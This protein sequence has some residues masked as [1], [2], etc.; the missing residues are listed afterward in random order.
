MNHYS[1]FLL[2]QEMSPVYDEKAKK[3]YD[4]DILQTAK[5]KP[6]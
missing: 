5:K 4:M 6:G 1:H 2:P 3:R